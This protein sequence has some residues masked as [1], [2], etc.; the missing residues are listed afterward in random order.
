MT[1]EGELKASVK[2]YLRL[3]GWFVF[4]VQQGMYSYPG[5]AD[6]VAMRDGICLWIETKTKPRIQS[7]A[8]IKFQNDIEEAGGI[9]LLIYSIDDL[10]GKIEEL[11]AEKISLF[12]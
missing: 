1:P 4:H 2:K 9:Y 12:A 3:T 6:I 11:T 7:T 10:I 8:Q 5:I